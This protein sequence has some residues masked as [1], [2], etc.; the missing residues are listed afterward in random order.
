MAVM[1]PGAP[2]PYAAWEAGRRATFAARHAIYDAIAIAIVGLAV[3]AGLRVRRLWVAIA[4]SSVLVLT[5]VDVASY[6][7][8]FCILLG[9]LAAAGREEGALAL[10]AIVVGRAANALP[11]ATGNPDLRY[12]VQSVVFL[13]WGATA[14]ALL[15]RHRRP[16]A[17]AAPSRRG[18]A[19]RRRATSS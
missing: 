10:A 5:A 18:R 12:G 4:A 9:L 16:R 1:Q 14:L 19:A 2:D 6:Y 17:V 7:C 13:V 3:W 15:A 11:I 8:A